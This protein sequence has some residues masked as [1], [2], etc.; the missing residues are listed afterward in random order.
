MT[1]AEIRTVCYRVDTTVFILLQTRE[2]VE[3]SANPTR[4]ASQRLTG[5]LLLFR[6]N[7]C[8]IRN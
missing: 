7:L 6:E 2:A 1:P 4:A 8:H 5:Q 3:N